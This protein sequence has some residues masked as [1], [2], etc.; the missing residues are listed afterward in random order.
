[1]SLE[2]KRFVVVALVVVEFPVMTK[3]ALMV[4]EALERKPPV[5]VERLATASVP[6]KLAA[7]EIVWELMAPEVMVFPP[8][9]K[10]PLEVMAPEVMRPVLREVEKR[11]VEE[12]VVEKKLVEVAL[13]VVLLLEIRLGNVELTVVV[14][15]KKAA[16]TSPTTL[17]LV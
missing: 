10:A 6:V 13:V 5:S 9:A 4:E 7:L 15:V 17:S 14:A 2:A 1:M 16:A 3:L 11:L 8:K 12:A